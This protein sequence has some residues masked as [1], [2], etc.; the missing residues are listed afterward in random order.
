MGDTI[1]QF[2]EN[3]QTNFYGPILE[4]VAVE[5]VHKIWSISFQKIGL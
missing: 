3:L 5:L 2:S 1:D 4:S